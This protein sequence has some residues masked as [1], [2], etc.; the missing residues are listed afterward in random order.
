MKTK[1]L[2]DMD[3]CGDPRECKKCMQ[4]CPLALFIMYP[5][6][7]IDNDPQE[8]KADVA[9]T[10]LCTRCNKCVDVCPNGA[11]KVL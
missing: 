5:P 1:I 7:E 9:F 3:L 4:I 8:W 10:D 2:V 6:S 11:V